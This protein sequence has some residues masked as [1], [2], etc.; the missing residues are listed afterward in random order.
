M[1]CYFVEHGYK[2]NGLEGSYA[3]YIK[4]CIKIITV[5]A[6]I[7]I[8]SKTMKV[9]FSCISNSPF[10]CHTMV[11]ILRGNKKKRERQ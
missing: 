3:C 6:S 1:N 10:P 8:F 7:L 5:I 4:L 2:N 11:E 9:R